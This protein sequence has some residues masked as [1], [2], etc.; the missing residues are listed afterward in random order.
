VGTANTSRQESDFGHQCWRFQ[1]F[2]HPVQK[3]PFSGVE[4]IGD[5]QRFSWGGVWLED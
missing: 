1:P 2:F 5:L 4:I 3:V